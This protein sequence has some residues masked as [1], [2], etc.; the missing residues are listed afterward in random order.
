M[1]EHYILDTAEVPSSTTPAGGGS[2][3]DGIPCQYNHNCTE[4]GK[5]QPPS[6]ARLTPNQKKM[7]VK[8]IMG[9]EW[10]ILKYGIERVGVLTL[11]FGVP[12]SGKGSFETW[13][14]RQQAKVWGF[15]QKRWHSLCTHVIAD[16]YEDWICVFELHEDGV[17]HLHV[18]V[19]TKEDIRT[20]TDIETLSNYKLPYWKRRG[21]HLR[22]KALAAEWTDLRRICCGYRFGRVE[23]LPVKKTGL[24]V[25]LYLGA[26]LIQTYNVLPPGGRRRLIRF[27]KGINEA[28]SPVNGFSI[29]SLGNL[30]YRTRLKIVAQM[31][32]FEHYGE[33]A[34]Y[35]GP[36]WN[37]LLKNL[38]AWVPMPFRFHKNDFDS[39]VAARVL[40]AYANDPKQHLDEREQAKIDDVARELVRRLEEALDENTE[41]L[42]ELRSRRV[43]ESVGDG[44][45]DPDAMQSDLF[46]DPYIPF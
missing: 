4:K 45:A 3:A 10:M 12:G 1:E 24:A 11:S 15:V 40:K 29:R 6:R 35:F 46:A 23:L 41:A 32:R 22:N 43:S 28:I 14:L 9:V 44:P 37:F 31:L 18:V 42:M 5:Y 38:I 19:V 16:R 7:L 2:G 26:Y 39:G 30:I 33:F 25:G 8:M 34:E 20:G 21:K 36:R 27:S 17:W 13:A